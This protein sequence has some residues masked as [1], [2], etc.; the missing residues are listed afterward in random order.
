M[1]T[2][3]INSCTFKGAIGEVLY[4]VNFLGPRNTAADHSDVG[5]VETDSELQMIGNIA[6]PGF[7]RGDRPNTAEGL[8]LKINALVKK[9]ANSKRRDGCSSAFDRLE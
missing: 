1:Y 9:L 7:T 6:E 3:D 5:G 2:D 8:V 4:A